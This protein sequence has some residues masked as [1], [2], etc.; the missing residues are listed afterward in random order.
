MN[1]PTSTLLLLLASIVDNCPPNTFLGESS[2]P[3]VIT[4]VYGPNPDMTL[5]DLDSRSLV[6][7][8]W[9]VIVPVVDGGNVVAPTEDGRY[10]IARL[11]AVP[12][13]STGPST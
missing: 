3:T 12:S 8:G 4:P 13:Q 10:L 11:R 9:L 5:A 2:L 1:E 6:A 7:M